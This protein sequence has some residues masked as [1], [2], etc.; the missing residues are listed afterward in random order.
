MVSKWATRFAPATTTCAC[1]SSWTCGLVRR[2]ASLTTAPRPARATPS[3]SI[4]CVH[5]RK[6]NYERV[7][8]TRHRA[9]G[10]K[11]VK[12]RGVGKGAARRPFS[13]AD[14]SA[15]ALQADLVI[16]RDLHVMVQAGS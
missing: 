5:G 7:I 11:A 3:K 12:G 8:T 15:G 13:W 2:P 4:T 10:T 16:L 1:T 6:S 14:Q 9:P